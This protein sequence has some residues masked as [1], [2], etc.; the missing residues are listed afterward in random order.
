M[1]LSAFEPAEYICARYGNGAVTSV[2][3]TG[4]RQHSP[5]QGQTE[6]G[7]KREKTGENEP[8]AASEE[9]NKGH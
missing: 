1:K 3:E 2:F 5:S 6:R 8:L 9:I 7:R 4:R